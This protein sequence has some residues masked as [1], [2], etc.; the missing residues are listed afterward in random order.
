MKPR[1]SQDLVERFLTMTGPLPLPLLN[2]P[3]QGR[4]PR[5]SRGGKP[6]NLTGQHPCSKAV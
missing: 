2:W 4:R 6:K 1:M 5:R 3:R